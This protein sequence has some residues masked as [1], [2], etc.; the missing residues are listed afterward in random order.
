[1][2]HS[3]GSAYVAVNT[4]V[5]NVE[6]LDP[7]TVGPRLETDPLFPERA[8]I[9]FARVLSVDPALAGLVGACD[10]DLPVGSLI[11]AIAQL[12]DIDPRALRADLLPRVRELVFTGFLAFA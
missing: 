8:N 1:M 11:D 6:A 2:F 4:V 7:A 10:G 9:G 3:R 5:V 12:L